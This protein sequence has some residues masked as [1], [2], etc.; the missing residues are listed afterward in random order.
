MSPIEP[1]PPNQPPTP[2]GGGGYG[3]QPPA[4]PPGGG[5]YGSEPPAGPPGG[6]GSQPPAGGP[7]PSGGS[8]SVGDAFG[9]AWKKFQANAATL[10][11]GTLL[12]AIVG[13]VLYFAGTMIISAIFGSGVDPIEVDPETGNITG[14]AGRGFFAA[15]VL[16]A[17][18]GF[19]ASL[20]V[21]IFLASY[22]K[23]LL[24][25]ADGEKPEIGDFFKFERIDKSV[26]LGLILAIGSLIGTILCYFPALIWGFL[27]A[28]A[29]FFLVDK[30]E[31]PVDAVKSSISFTRKDLGTMILVYLAVLA[32]IFVGAI[33]CGIGLLV[34][35]PVAGLIYTYTYRTLNGGTVTA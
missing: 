30:K 17:L 28:Y 11:V 22:V 9:W 5:G 12:V 31:E 1:P 29:L 4:G 16:T 34:A 35:G 13:F 32:T 20:A 27:T 10:I 21:Y 6:Y 23:V 19:I 25:I 33:A 7:P 15:L 26:I 3:S 18:G 24:R 2:P 8:F 14:G